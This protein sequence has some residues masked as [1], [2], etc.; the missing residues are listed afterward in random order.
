MACVVQ[1]LHQRVAQDGRAADHAIEPRVRRH[2]DDGRNAASFFADEDALGAAKLDF[3]ARVR[4][5]A[6]LVFQAL[7]LDRVLAAV[8]AKARHEEARQRAVFCAHARDH[9]VCIAH[10][11]REE[12]LVACDGVRCATGLAAQ[13]RCHRGVATHIGAALL[14]S[15]A[16]ADEDG[17]LLAPRQIACVVL[18]GV[19][20]RPQIGKQRGL[21]LQDG[22][23]GERHRRRAQRAGFDLR[24]HEVTGGARRPCTRARVG[25]RQGLQPL[26]AHQ[27]EQRVP[28]G[29][30]ADGIDSLAGA[31]VGVEFRVIGVG[32]RGPLQRLGRAELVT[33][34]LQRA[35]V[36]TAAQ[37]FER[38]L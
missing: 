2:L 6:E 7:D 9:Q 5:V 31:A 20:T 32:L 29:G 11:R 30:E 12:P 1:G 34:R 35:G 25:E 16:H 14:F 38:T 37:A 36:P 26:A 19:E 23:A 22:D 27:A 24:L 3:A 21:F 10:R 15:H 17:G 18:P 13:G 28:G 33:E 8:I 4:A